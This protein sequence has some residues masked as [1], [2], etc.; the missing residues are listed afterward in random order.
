MR[1]CHLVGEALTKLRTPKKGRDLLLGA[2]SALAFGRSILQ[3][4]VTV[5]MVQGL[6][7]VGVTNEENKVLRLIVMG[8]AFDSLED[9]SYILINALWRPVGQYTYCDH[10]GQVFRNYEG[11]MLARMG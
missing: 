11:S 4:E 6:V 9:R 5:F 1:Q 10:S 3:P 7:R 2:I 8:D